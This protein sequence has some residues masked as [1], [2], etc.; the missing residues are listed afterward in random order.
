MIIHPTTKVSEVVTSNI[1]S[2]DVFTRYGIDFC[3]GGGVSLEKACEKK[4][5]DLNS[6]LSDLQQLEQHVLPAHDYRKWSPAF[7]ADYIVNTHHAYVREAL[8]VLREYMLKVAR[9]HADGFPAILEIRDLFV[10]L[11]DELTSHMEKEEL[12]LFPYIRSMVSLGQAMQ[13]PAFGRVKHPIQVM[14]NEHDAAGENMHRIAA[15]SGGYNP[16]EWACNTFRALFAKLHEFEEDLHMHVHLENNLLFPK[17]EAMEQVI[18]RES[19]SLET[20]N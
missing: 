11:D 17:A 3:C 15:L 4:N 9:V 18:L 20:G 19:G 14:R 7:L 1:R 13:R 12:I 8:P 5:I 10:Q 2:A 16:P 6:V